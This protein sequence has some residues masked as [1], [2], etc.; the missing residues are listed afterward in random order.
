MIHNI[1]ALSNSEKKQVM[2]TYFFS[3]CQS[4]R[5]VRGRFQIAQDLNC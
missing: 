2:K 5:N 4:I 3:W 1:I